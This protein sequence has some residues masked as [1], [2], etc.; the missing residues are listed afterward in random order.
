MNNSNNKMK[1]KMTK[2][3]VKIIAIE[4]MRKNGMLLR[5]KMEMDSCQEVK[6]FCQKSLPLLFKTITSLKYRKINS[7]TYHKSSKMLKTVT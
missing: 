1:I 2:I 6:K 7:K 4:M 5:R 3:M